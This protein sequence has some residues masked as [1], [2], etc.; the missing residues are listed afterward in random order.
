M[1]FFLIAVVLFAAAEFVI[2]WWALPVV[3]LA[4]GLIGARRTR[5]GVTIASAALVAWAGLYAWSAMQGDGVTFMQQL[6]ASMSLKPAQLVSGAMGMPALLAGPA[7]AL[8][9]GIM[10]LIRRESATDMTA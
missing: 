3:G 5:V 6:A 7:A 8:G 4:L 10:G 1:F 9:A 2:G